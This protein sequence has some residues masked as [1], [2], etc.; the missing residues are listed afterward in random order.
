M[1]RPALRTRSR[2]RQN[3]RLPGGRSTIHY[4]KEKTNPPICSRCDAQ[5]LGVPRLSPSKLRKLPINRK[6]PERIYGGD[7]CPKCLRDLLKQATR[8]A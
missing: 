7:L 1:P 4:K 2:K 6:R 8:S 3:V 5:I